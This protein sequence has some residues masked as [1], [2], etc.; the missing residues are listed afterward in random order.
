MQRILKYMII[1]RYHTTAQNLYIDVADK[2][3]E[4]VVKLK[5]LGRT[6]TSKITLTRNF[7]ADKIRKRLLPCS[8]ESFVFPFAI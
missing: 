6:V 8:S 3:F 5:H 4:N 7:R 1:S 2:Y